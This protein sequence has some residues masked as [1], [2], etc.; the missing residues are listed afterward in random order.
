[1]ATSTPTTPNPPSTPA[2]AATYSLTGQVTN[3]ATGS[4]IAAAIV[5]VAGGP[6]SGKTATTDG[7]GR[8]ALASLQPATFNVGVTAENYVSAISSVTLAGNQTLSFALDAKTV[9]P[10]SATLSVGAT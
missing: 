8:Y 3:R 1:R 4:T 9:T 5:T 6:D 2:P 7:S 10:C